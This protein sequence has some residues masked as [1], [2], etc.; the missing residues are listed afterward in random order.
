MSTETN[1]KEAV[2][3]T[4]NI[5]YVGDGNSRLSMFRG[6]N[7]LK[8]F[9]SFYDRHANVKFLTASVDMLRTLD[10][11]T[12]KKLGINTLWIDNVVDPLSVQNLNK[13][14]QD[15]MTEVDPEWRANLSN[16]KDNKEEST[17]YILDLK[18]KRSDVLRLFYALDE[19]VW[20][21]PVG[22]SQSI[23]NVRIIENFM[24]IVDVVVVP[25]DTL[26]DA[27]KH[28]NL[29]SEEVD[30]AIL[31][32][33]VNHDFF[34]VF[35]NMKHELIMDYNKAPK[36]N[37]L[38]KGLVIPENVQKFIEYGY[39]NFNITISSVGELSE[40]VMKLIEDGKVKTMY[41]WANPSSNKKN[42]STTYAIERDAE[43]DILVYTFPEDMSKNFYDLTMGDEDVLFAAASGTVPV[44]GCEHI[45]FEESHLY[46]ASGLVFS[47]K[48]DYMDLFKM[49]RNNY[50]DAT[51]FNAALNGCRR[52]LDFRTS[53]SP[54]I[55]SVLYGLLLGRKKA[56]ELSESLKSKMKE[57]DSTTP[58]SD[59]QEK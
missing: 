55:M 47:P 23:Q 58:T 21:A 43:F 14:T 28:F 7:L 8:T 48:T 25:T 16:I 18:Q 37:V 1:K 45:G 34:P 29:I 19:F 22:R 40:R 13:L 53:T 54:S 51:K 3:E 38:V 46:N 27:I 59:S 9:S 26:M 30:I 2:K 24:N 49:V 15:L 10:L 17:K 6:E 44:V 39:K 32:T 50:L 36:P 4:F 11:D 35:K 33:S 52:I 31:P 57:M 20:E 42:F 12:V 56:T 5:L 41:H